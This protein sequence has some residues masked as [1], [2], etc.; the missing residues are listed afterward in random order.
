MFPS[1]VLKRKLAEKKMKV[2]KF[3]FT[4][5]KDFSSV[6]V[7]N[8][9]NAILESEIATVRDTPF[10]V[11]DLFAKGPI[12]RH[13]LNNRT[14][15]CKHK[16]PDRPAKYHFS[17]PESF[18]PRSDDSSL[19]K[20]GNKAFGFSNPSTDFDEQKSS[21][22]Q[23]V[24]KA[25][26]TIKSAIKDLNSAEEFQHL[27]NGVLLKFRQLF[28]DRQARL[29]KKEEKR[30]VANEKRKASEEKRKAAEEAAAATTAA[31]LAANG[32]HGGCDCCS[33]F[34]IY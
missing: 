10:P 15:H 1:T 7:P 28:E 14:S 21:G 6:I 19:P 8:N 27:R 20:G 12:C 30:K 5:G 2:E 26:F 16:L 18:I 33:H 4:S 9:D 29:K 23:K 11:I 13:I 24:E 22:N 25:K 34:I 31:S 3:A 32:F 17:L